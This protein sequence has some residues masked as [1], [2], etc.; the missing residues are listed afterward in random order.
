MRLLTNFGSFAKI[1][2]APKE[3][4]MLCPGIGDVK[5]TRLYNTF[6]RPFIPDASKN[7]PSD[8]EYQ[9]IAAIRAQNEAQSRLDSLAKRKGAVEFYDHSLSSM[10]LLSTAL[11]SNISSSSSTSSPTSIS[12]NLPSTVDTPCSLSNNSS[13]SSSNSPSSSSSIGSSNTDPLSTSVLSS[14]LTDIA[15]STANTTNQSSTTD[16]SAN[17]FDY[18][19]FV[20]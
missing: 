18:S 19:D 11:N 15:E 4:L 17:T 16:N 10:L 7:K 14:S 13:S 5:L 12:N 3:D 8:A 1:V 9:Q 20:S 2:L 6:R